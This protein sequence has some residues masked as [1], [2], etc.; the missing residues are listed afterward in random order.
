M[1]PTVLLGLFLS[2][3]ALADVPTTRDALL[4][5]YR[6][7]LN[8]HARYVAFAAQA[9][10]EGL[11]YVARLFRATAEA[12]RVRGESH[13]RALRRLGGAPSVE[14]AQIPVASTRVNLLRTLAHEN[15]ELRRGQLQV[16]QAREEGNADAALGFLLARGGHESLVRL[17]GEALRYPRRKVDAGDELHVCR[18]CGHVARGP[19][20]DRCPVSLS[21]AEA[22][23][24]V[25]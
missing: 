7:D 25:D 16:E 13:S 23:T 3:P 1:F 19:A 2:F 5:A 21:S 18:T 17:L 14:T 24:R 8:E 12:E 6:E 22:F 9:E 20:P 4:L 15:A 10:R 11:G